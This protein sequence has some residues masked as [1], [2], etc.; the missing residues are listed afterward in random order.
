MRTAGRGGGGRRREELAKR[1]VHAARDARVVGEEAA[2]GRRR[3]Q[4]DAHAPREA[5][6]LLLPFREHVRL[7]LVKDLQAVLD[8]AEVDER[9]AERA[10]EAGE[11]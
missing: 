11:R 9:V 8:R 6:E 2:A 4:G 7:E 1:P 3:R 10:P 5:P